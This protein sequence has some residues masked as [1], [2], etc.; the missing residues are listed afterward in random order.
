MTVNTSHLYPR[1]R[2]IDAR[3]AYHGGGA[4]YVLRDPL[5]IASH[6]LLV[7]RELAPALLL[8]DGTI[9]RDDMRTE[10]RARYGLQVDAGVIDE[11]LA[12]LDEALLL[13][14]QRYGAARDAA[15]AA[16]R[17]Q[18]YRVPALAGQAYPAEPAALRVLLD[19]YLAEVE[20]VTPLDAGR[21]L[22]SPH[23]DY[24]RG[25]RIYAAAWKRAATMARDAE[26]AVVLGTDH[27]GPALLTLTRQ[28][29]ATPYGVLPTDQGCVDEL[30]TAIGDDVAFAGE[31]YH[32]GEHAIELV[33]VWLHHMR[34]GEPLPLVPILTGSFAPFMRGDGR[35]PQRDPALEALAAAIR[36]I[37]G[38]RKTLIIASGDLSHVGPAF[39][40]ASLSAADKARLRGEDD[41]AVA[42][43]VA[44]D[45]PGFFDT[46]AGI[47]D[48]TN[49][50]GLPPGYLA[51]RALGDARGELLGYQQCPADEHDTS[52][53][54]IAGIVWA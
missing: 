12:A 37:A 39:G 27:Y 11:L 46:V 16:Y 23:I 45:A 30:A 1:L 33:A 40:G 42:R 4:V 7:A 24:A 54:S 44:G 2:Q 53:V 52:V 50:C 15:I 29:Y 10:L 26:L 20:G 14:N 31:L 8:C 48:R 13:D 47:G 19:G 3:L 28:S 35:S 9:H 22:F 6:A 43:L 49:I 38:R 5:Q 21:G 34:G 32:R 41:Q 17:A 51:L 25:G 36:A 18:P